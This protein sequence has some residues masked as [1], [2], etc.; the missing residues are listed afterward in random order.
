[1]AT[2]K[3]TAESRAKRVAAEAATAAAVAAAAARAGEGRSA[4]KGGRAA[5]VVEEVVEGEG[6]RRESERRPSVVFILLDCRAGNVAARPIAGAVWHG[7][8]A[9]IWSR[10][11][12]GEKRGERELGTALMIERKREKKKK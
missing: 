2:A 4:R 3:S 6:R 10:I 8:D 12:A 11:G 7:I 9:L 1:V 5:E